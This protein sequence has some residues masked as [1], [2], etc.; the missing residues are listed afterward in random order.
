MNNQFEKIK[1]INKPFEEIVLFDVGGTTH[2]TQRSTLTSV[3]DSKFEIIFNGNHELKIIDK[4]VFIDRNPKVFGMV[5]DYLR[6][7]EKEYLI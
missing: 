4:K 2:K 6:N 1:H 3:P 7:N 5:L